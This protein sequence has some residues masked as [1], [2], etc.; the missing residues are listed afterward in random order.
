MTGHIVSDALNND[1]LKRF[2]K[3]KG[4]VRNNYTVLPISFRNVSKIEN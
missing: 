2:P 1:L 3:K 4:N